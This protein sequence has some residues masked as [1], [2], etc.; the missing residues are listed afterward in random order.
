[1][2]YEFCYDSVLAFDSFSLLEFGPISPIHHFSVAGDAMSNI[3][4]A[5]WQSDQVLMVLEVQSS[6][7]KACSDTEAAPLRQLLREFEEEGI[8]DTSIHGHECY[9]PDESEAGTGVLAT[10]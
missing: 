8:I 4:V 2:R 7:S 10:Y 6:T 5:K 9:R 3:I 1:M